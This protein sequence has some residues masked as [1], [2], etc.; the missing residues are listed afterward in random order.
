MIDRLVTDIMLAL[1]GFI[2]FA[3]VV[4][5]AI[6]A[7]EGIAGVPLALRSEAFHT[8]VV[9]LAILAVIFVVAGQVAEATSRKNPPRH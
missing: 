5:L 7:L 3:G 9:I 8:V 1:V 4:V 2:W 6:L